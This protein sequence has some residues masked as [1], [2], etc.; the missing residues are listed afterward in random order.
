MTWSAIRYTGYC[1]LVIDSVPGSFGGTAT[2]RIRGPDEAG[3][4][5]DSLELKR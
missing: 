3:G 2:L 4:E 1:L 5:L